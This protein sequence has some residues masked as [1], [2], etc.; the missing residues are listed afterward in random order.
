MPS[1][2]HF[3]EVLRQH[4]VVAVARRARTRWNSPCVPSNTVRGPMKPCCAEARRLHARLRR[5]AR[6]QPLGPRA[7][8]EILDDAARSGC[9]RCRAHRR[10]AARSRPSATPTPSAA[11]RSCR[12]RSSDGNPPCGSPSARTI[13]KPAQRFDARS[14]MP[15]QR[16]AAVAAEALA[17]GEHRGHDH[18]AAVHG[19]ALERVVEILAVRGRAVDERGLLGAVRLRVADRRAGAAGIERALHRLHVIG[20]ARRDAQPDDVDQQLLGTLRTACGIAPASA[21]A[22]AR[23]SARRRHDRARELMCFASSLAHRNRARHQLIG[24]LHARLRAAAAARAR[25]TRR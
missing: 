20:V 11:R 21:R 14:T 23:Q 13:A 1:M 7:F 12:A 6:V 9:R 5:P 10:S 24:S 19:A 22:P 16:R 8:G 17:R 3:A 15:E 25:R 4:V 2:Y 18:R